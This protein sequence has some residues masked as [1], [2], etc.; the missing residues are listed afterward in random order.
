LG[1]SSKLPHL[2]NFVLQKS[3]IL[4]DSRR[5]DGLSKG[6]GFS[7]MLGINA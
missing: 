3:S 6:Q 7:G 2:A 4:E 1:G 5:S